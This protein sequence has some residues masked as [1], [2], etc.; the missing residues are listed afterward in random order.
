[1]FNGIDT[2]EVTRLPIHR[3]VTWSEVRDV[4]TRYVVHASNQD[5][6]ADVP[7]RILKVAGPYAK[8]FTDGMDFISPHVDYNLRVVETSHE[9]GQAEVFVHEFREAPL[10]FV[11]ED[12]VDSE[13][14]P[15]TVKLDKFPLQQDIIEAETFW[16]NAAAYHSF[17]VEPINA[18]DSPVMRYDCTLHLHLFVNR[19][20]P[21]SS[22]KLHVGDGRTHGDTQWE[23]SML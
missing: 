9:T 8:E 23:Y 2:S 15:L 17:D 6:I 16:T 20:L 1:M 11:G 19:H 5:W 3:V 12:F 13:G 21:D 18:S 22:F 10:F 7:K 14:F 4:L